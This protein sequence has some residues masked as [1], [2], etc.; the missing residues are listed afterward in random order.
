MP[1]HAK[2]GPGRQL[3]FKVISNHGIA[4]NDVAVRVAD[5][6]VA[7][8]AVSGLVLPCDRASPPQTAGDFR[9]AAV[10]RAGASLRSMSQSA[11]RASPAGPAPRG[12]PPGNGQWSAALRATRPKAGTPCGQ[13][14]QTV[15]Q[16]RRYS[17]V[18]R[19]RRRPPSYAPQAAFRCPAAPRHAAISAAHFARAATRWRSF[20]WP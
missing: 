10:R 9:S 3:L 14:R 12:L 6:V 7:P 16:A 4:I 11:F 8:G 18:C 1:R 13:C 17:T 15:A 20:T 19:A 2:P 5:E